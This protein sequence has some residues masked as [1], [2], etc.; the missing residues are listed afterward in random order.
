VSFANKITDDMGRAGAH[1]QEAI[2]KPIVSFR[3]RPRACINA[4]S[5][6]FERVLSQR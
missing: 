1:V 3:R 2:R 4:K 6:H 5:E